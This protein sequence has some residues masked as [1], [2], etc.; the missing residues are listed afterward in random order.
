MGKRLE[1]YERC[2]ACMGQG[3]IAPTRAI[4]AYCNGEGFPLTRVE[5]TTDARDDSKERRLKLVKPTA[6]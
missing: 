3:S 5:I 1:I 6:K 4:C 2:P